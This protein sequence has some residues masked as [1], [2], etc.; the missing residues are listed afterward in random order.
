MGLIYQQPWKRQPQQVQRCRGGFVPD[1]LWTPQGGHR[2]HGRV[3]VTADNYSGAIVA[4][5]NALATAHD[6]SSQDENFPIS[7]TAQYPFVQAGVFVIT[8]AYDGTART[9]VGI[10]D[11]PGTNLYGGLGQRQFGDDGVASWYRPN[12]G[13]F[14]ATIYGPTAE[15][16]KTYNVIRIDRG[17]LDHTM[18]VNGVKYTNTA[19]NTGAASGTWGH[20]TI[21]ASN[22]NG[23]RLF[24]G[25]QKVALAFCGPH[26]PGDAWAREWS[27]NPWSMFAPLPRALWAPSAAAGGFFAR[28]YYD[29]I[30][31][32]R[33]GS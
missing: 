17:A 13:D 6:A 21:G 4:I 2:L 26:A 30:G 19:D 15:V 33:I 5:P 32:S 18:F 28:P 12:G 1:H 27:V 20:F 25:D 23:T 16:G 7:S 8:A 9:A 24:R 29:M 22:R 31:Q 10:G 3:E 11:G 14:D